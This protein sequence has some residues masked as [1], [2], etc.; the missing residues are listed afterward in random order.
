MPISLAIFAITGAAPVPVPPPI[1][2]VMKTIFV[3]CPRTAFISSML[4]IADFSPT[5]GSAPAPKPSVMATPNCTFVE[6][7]LL[8]SVC[9]SVLQMIKSTPFI[10]FSYICFSAL[11]PPPP[12]PIT[13]MIDEVPFGKSNENPVLNVF[14]IFIFL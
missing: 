14:S 10:P 7:G 3:P 9:A 13:L 11:L 8:S 5:S 12:T 6:I 2:A 1:P 4:S